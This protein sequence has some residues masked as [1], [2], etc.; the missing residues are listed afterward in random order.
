MASW[1]LFAIKGK[2]M[3]LTHYRRLHP[4]IQ[5]IGKTFKLY[6]AV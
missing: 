4:E 5:S 1:L 2:G 3:I 6:T